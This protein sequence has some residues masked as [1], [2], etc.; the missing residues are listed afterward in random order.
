MFGRPP[1][2]ASHHF[3]TQLPSYC[4]PALDSSGRL[5]LPNI[6]LF[7]LAY[8]L[9]D[10]MND[11]V[12]LRLV[13]YSSVLDHD[14]TLSEWLLSM[15]RELDLD[16]YHIARALASDQPS[17]R[18]T[19]VQSIIIRTS[20]YHIRFTLHRPYTTAG[21]MKEKSLESA[22]AAADSVIALIGQ[23]RPDFL[24]NR[25]LNV[26]GHMS[27]GPFHVFSAAMFFSFQLIRDPDQPHANRF[28]SNIAKALSILDNARDI[29]IANKAYNIL[30]A[31]SPLCSAEYSVEQSEERERKKA[32]ILRTVRK[33]AF[34]YHDSPKYLRTYVDSPN[35]RGS[36][37]SPANSMSSAS[38]TGFSSTQNV[39]APVSSMR[40][41]A[42]NQQPISSLTSSIYSGVQHYMPPSIPPQQSSFYIPLESSYQSYGA[43]HSQQINDDRP[44]FTNEPDETWG[45]S[46][47]FGP[48][49][50]SSLLDT[51]QRPPSG[52]AI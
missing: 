7:R 24:A 42:S 5:Y 52:N 3:D 20:F 38:P 17:I 46:V 36:T 27:W 51:M 33:L 37:S 29:P 47:G 41:S 2:I 28:R 9:G 19:G 12:S 23:T 34:P 50:W 15:P 11:A 44:Y 32:A 25:T 39:L 49:E 45:A 30:D 26:P 1:S 22:I 14:R 35:T 8:I 16:E 40:D 43:P 4:D 31:L 21:R 48:G 13:P 18:R 6:T 10:I